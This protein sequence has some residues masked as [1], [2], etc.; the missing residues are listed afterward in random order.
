MYDWYL[1][2]DLKIPWAKHVSRM[3]SLEAFGVRLQDLTQITVRFLPRN[4]CN[5]FSA[6]DGRVLKHDLVMRVWSDVTA[7]KDWVEIIRRGSYL[8]F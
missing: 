4:G 3:S 1:I 5:Y 8:K 2:L 7:E 6:P